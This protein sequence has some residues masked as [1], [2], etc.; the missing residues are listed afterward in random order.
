MNYKNRPAEAKRTKFSNLRIH[1]RDVSK[2]HLQ[3]SIFW[4]KNDI[5]PPSEKLY[6]SPSRDMLI[7]SSYHALFVLILPYFAFNLSFYFLFSVCLPPS[8]FFYIFPLSLLLFIF[9]P[10]WHQ[11]IFPPPPGGWVGGIFHIID[12]WPFEQ[13]STYTKRMKKREND[14]KRRN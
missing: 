14:R 9:S 5:P 6:F 7:F 11:L 10:K 1:S 2:C 3:G 12:P 8:F 13:Q 4:P